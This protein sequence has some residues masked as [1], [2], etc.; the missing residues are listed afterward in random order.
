M[1]IQV[2]SEVAGYRIDGLLGRGGMGMVYVA[3]HL[4]L[5]RKAALKTLLVELASD[6]DFKT[7]FIRESQMVAAIDHPN[8]IPIYDAG[9]IEGTAYIAMRFVPGRDLDVMIKQQKQ[10]SAH[11]TLSI[12]DQAG[13][14]LD[15]AHVRGL[16]HRDIKPAN[17]LI[18]ET[19]DRIYLT[20][21]GIAKE[22]G[23]S[24]GL[25]QPGFF[26]GT[27]DY[28]APEQIEG[29][30]IGP[31]ADLY[32]F[33]CVLFEC[34]SGRKP[35]VGPTDIAVVKAHV[36]DP[37]PSL[38]EL[39]PDLPPEIDEVIRRALAKMEADRYGSC[40]ELIEAAQMA[41]GASGG[42]AAAAAQAPPAAAAAP[43][44]TPNF[45]G[46]AAA[47][48]ATA[49]ANAPV[50]AL[51]TAA[52]AIVG[53]EHELADVTALL[54]DPAV[55]LV[56]LTGLGGTG[57][58][59]LGVAAAATV[60]SEFDLVAF[61]D[62]APVQDPGFVPT[63]VAQALGVRESANQS[64]LEA[65][66]DRLGGRSALLVLD[67]FEQVLAAAAFV[68]ELLAALPAAKVLVTSQG[69]LRLRG[70]REYAV[71]P[72]SLPE[73]GDVSDLDA[74]RASPAVGLFIE[75]A[76][77]SS[78]TFELTEENADAVV[79]ICRRL[80][81]IPL[82][83]ELAAARVKLLPPQALRNR[84]QRRLELLTGGSAG[85]PERQRTL[86]GAIDWSYDLLTET[87]Q[88]VMTR[89]GAFVGGCSLEAA[90][91]VCGEPFDLG[92]GGMVDTLASLVDKS[93]VRQSEGAD[94][95]PR[96]GML[97]TIREYAGER[98]EER[99][100]AEHV[101]RLHADRFLNLVEAAEPE[102]T[103]SNQAAWLQR[104]DDENGNIRAALAWSLEAGEVDLALRFAG[105]LVRYWS[106]RGYMLEGRDWLREAIERGAATPPGVQAKAAFAAGYADLGL[107]EFGD[108]ERWFQRS[109][110]LART[111][112]D[113][114][115]E[116]AALA[117]LA[118]VAMTR[119]SD[120]EGEARSLAEQAVALGREV[121]D[122]RT[123]SGALN[124]LAELAMQR[125]DPAGALGMFEESLALRRGLGDRR[126]VANSL[127]TLGRARVADEDTEEANRL[128]DEALALARELRDTWGE[129]VA[130]GALGK[131]R[132]LEGTPD[133]AAELC[134]AALRLAV[135]RGDRRAAADALLGIAAAVAAES[136]DTAARLYGASQG[137][138]ESTKSVASPAERVIERRLIPTLTESLGGDELAATLTKGRGLDFEA[139]VAL[140]L[141]GDARRPTTVAAR[142]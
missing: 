128:L 106:I 38:T 8:I 86:R 108:A 59:R 39:R 71:P 37:P 61:I 29:Q 111:A 93:L 75:R 124:T 107:G 100:E 73:A 102:L 14:A 96:F 58:T 57:K 84:L 43:A 7:R 135:A 110:E 53:R 67:N 140:A 36:L 10:L 18:E 45:D 104:L 16:V 25:T 109:L 114:G 112:A 40:R 22:A 62:L 80:D 98:L 49:T 70:E 24:G 33:G 137:L 17:I 89:L 51:P 90:E 54:R 88:A 95:E 20:D 30:E 139:A 133:E 31:P 5:G 115:A 116:A 26:L 74:L 28:A 92:I 85:L 72:L 12:L 44:A 77:E 125:G 46:V 132:L 68:S 120:G 48:L 130:L 76:Q 101:R 13:A 79:E 99:G 136:G 141:P 138:L 131:V 126:L 65:V 118:W 41:L 56:T 4:L 6:S 91:G 23:A 94:G 97:E 66:R 52:T 55:R 47:P 42:A 19:T 123:T 1:S 117:Q 34:L 105:A 103:R 122:K 11:E 119:T 142:A 81:G 127:V 15:A 63:A 9:E 21:F 113:S 82:A 35:F 32:A 3:E 64:A 27:V 60:S 134:R 50:F 87:E 129:S 83:I 69:T 121:D 2:G 78:A